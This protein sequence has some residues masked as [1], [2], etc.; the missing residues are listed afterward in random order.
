MRFEM[1]LMFPLF[2]CEVLLNTENRCR[3]HGSDFFLTDLFNTF[4]LYHKKCIVS[5][6]KRLSQRCYMNTLVVF[7]LSAVIGYLCSY[8]FMNR[9]RS[10]HLLSGKRRY[11]VQSFFYKQYVYLAV[12]EP[13]SCLRFYRHRIAKSLEDLGEGMKGTYTFENR[14][15]E[16]IEARTCS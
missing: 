13:S 2:L 6:G 9:I 7:V 8:V 16:C 11:V 10:L 15:D 3:V 4:T 1:T 12:V 14:A 5:N